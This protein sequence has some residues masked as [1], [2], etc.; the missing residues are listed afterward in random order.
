MVAAD[1]GRRNATYTKFLLK[2]I[3][4]PGLTVEQVLKRVRVDV[5]RETGNKQVPWES[6]S[7][8]GDFYFAPKRAIA[9]KRERERL[10]RD[11][12]ELERLKIE[13]KRLEVERRRMEAKKLEIA[14]LRPENGYSPLEYKKIGRDGN[15][16]AYSNGIVLDIATGLEWIAGPDRDMNWNESISWVESLYITNGGW[17]MP[18]IEELRTLYRKGRGS[19]NMTSLLKTSG[20][21]VWSGIDFNTWGDRGAFCFVFKYG[22]KGLSNFEWSIGYRAFAVRSQR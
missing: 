3:T 11:H 1:G 18:S 15:F 17:R 8:T 22:R 13:S 2:Y 20:W 7:L 5:I 16:I 21:W 14:K 12:K 9:I 6:S 4:T 10:E 19:R